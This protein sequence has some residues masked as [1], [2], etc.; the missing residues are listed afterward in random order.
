MPIAAVHPE[1]YRWLLN[2]FETVITVMIRLWS[3]I[4]IVH[5]FHDTSERAISGTL[6][7]FVTVLTVTN[8]LLRVPLTD[9]HFRNSSSRTIIEGLKSFDI[10]RR[11][12]DPLLSVSEGLK[13]IETLHI[14]LYS[15]VLGPS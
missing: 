3:I 14:E 15:I 11:V 8:L 6:K 2:S 13:T 4:E 12:S 5:R 7:S 1:E 10:D 9:D